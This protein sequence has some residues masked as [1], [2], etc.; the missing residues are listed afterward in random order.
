[1]AEILLMKILCKFLQY[2][3]TQF[4]TEVQFNDILQTGVQSTINISK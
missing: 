1:M 3:F 2:K 4:L